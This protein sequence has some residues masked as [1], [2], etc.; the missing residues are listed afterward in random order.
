LEDQL[1]KQVEDELP[2][3][4]LETVV[5]AQVQDGVLKESRVH[6]GLGILLLALLDGL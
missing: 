1:I 4:G 5:H 2:S 3:F 6:K